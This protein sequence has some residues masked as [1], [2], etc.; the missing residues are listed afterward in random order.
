MNDPK[1]SSPPPLHKASPDYDYSNH[2][3]SLP[4]S[5][6]SS[7]RSA[8]S[9][10]PSS[11]SSR[12]QPQN[13]PT[14]KE[15]LR[16]LAEEQE[17][18]RDL[19]Q[20]LTFSTS[21]LVF[22]QDRADMAERKIKE[23]VIR[24]KDANDARI[25]AQADAARLREELKLYK[26]ALEEAQKEIFK[27]QN[28]LKD[29]EGRKREAEEEATQLRRKLRKMNEE[30]M[31]DMAREEGRKQGLEEGL[32]M[33]KDIGYLRG[34][35]QG[36]VNGRSTADKMMERYFSPPSESEARRSRGEPDLPPEGDVPYTATT[37]RFPVS[38][39]SAPS[40]SSSS[41]SE[42]EVSRY[43]RTGGTRTASARTTMYSPAQPH[44]EIPPDGFIPEVDAS[45]IIRLPPPHELV[46]PP[47]APA[48]Q[49]PSSRPVSPSPYMPPVPVPGDVPALMVPEPRSPGNPL[50]ELSG[51]RQHRRVRRRS[52]GESVSSSTRTSELDLLNA[53]E[54]VPNRG[55]RS[56]G[57]SVIPEVASFQEASTPSSRSM[58]QMGEDRVD[59]AGFVHV[60]MPAPLTAAEMA[61]LKARSGSQSLSVD[62][63]GYSRPGSTSSSGT[64]NITIQPP[65][66]PASNNSA[67]TTRP[68]LLS[69]ADADRPIPLP[70]QTAAVDTTDS[71]IVM[72]LPDGALPPGFVPAGLQGTETS[73]TGA[74]VPL[75]P[76]TMGSYHS[77]LPSQGYGGYDGSVRG[78]METPVVIPPPSGRSGHE[79][80]DDSSSDTDTLTTP[81][82]RYQV[83]SSGGYSAA[84]VALPGSIPHLGLHSASASGDI[85]LVQYALSHGQPVN[86]VLDGVLPLHAASAGGNVLVVNFLI[87][88]GADVNAPRLPR[89]YSDRSRDTTT[90]IVGTSGSTPLHFAAA[91]GHLP[92]VRTLLS[93]GAIPDRADK[94][95][96]TPELIARQNGW[97]ECAD[98]L[99]HASTSVKV[100]H[101]VSATT[102]SDAFSQQRGP[103]C[104]VEHLEASLRKRL[105]FKRSVDHTLSATG[106]TSDPE[107]K[108]PLA[109]SSIRSDQESL[110]QDSRLEDNSA[111]LATQT[112]PSPFGRPP[113]LPQ[114]LDESSI[115]P[116][117]PVR[118]V[119][120]RSAGTGADSRKLHSKLSLLSLFKKSNTDGSS[121]SV[122]SLSESPVP[123]SSPSRPVPIPTFRAHPSNTP[124]VSPRS[125]QIPLSSSPRDTSHRQYHRHK[126]ESSTSLINVRA[127]PLHPADLH[128]V[129]T[130]ERSRNPSVS[131]A[132]II[133]AP[134]DDSGSADGSPSI[135]GTPIKS[136]ILRMH[137][138]SH[139]GHGSI[140]QPGSLPRNI[141]FERSVSESTHLPG[142]ARSPGS[143][144]QLE[145]RMRS[146]GIAP[147]GQHEDEYDRIPDTIEESPIVPHAIP[148]VFVN[149]ILDHD[150]DPEEEYGIPLSNLELHPTQDHS[151]ANSQ[152]PFSINVP[153]TED[154]LAESR[155]RGDSV[156]S[157]STTAT[158]STY[159]QSSSSDAAWSITT[160][161]TPHL[162]GSP[163]I[164][165]ALGE[166]DVEETR[167]PHQPPRRLHFPFD[168]DISSI[169]SRA[170]AE[171]LVQRTQQS[172]LNM[173]QYIEQ[174]AERDSETG[175]TPLSAKLAAYGES[176]A[177]ERRLKEKA[178]VETP[179]Q[180]ADVGH[181]NGGVS[182]LSATKP[183]HVYPSPH[184]GRSAS[185]SGN[186]SQ[187]QQSE[188]L[189]QTT[190][191]DDSPGFASSPPRE[192]IQT[193]P[194]S[195]SPDANSDL[196]SSCHAGVPLSRVSTAPSYDPTSARRGRERD[197]SRSFQKLTRMGFSTFDNWHPSPVK[198]RASRSPP[199]SLRFG[200]RT[201]MQSFQGK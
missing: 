108:P 18:T 124:P 22:E 16:M 10:T 156:S 188:H 59:E 146:L 99:A 68:H 149:V 56:S 97:I 75:P 92:V 57:L 138:R 115:K 181:F 112:M 102:P 195:R 88:S 201:I 164:Q 153:P 2:E 73:Y 27:A 182:L 90:P 155:L 4:P 51:E 6:P 194:R 81:P 5:P 12:G 105:H 144:A 122:A 74:G 140:S 35:N 48:D 63:K 80:T 15:L 21:Q 17:T 150:D 189:R 52:S 154:A 197:P 85:G 171:E 161:S 76:S 132:S 29:I 96:I 19:Q 94:H 82:R 54:Y 89:R 62:Q 123:L 110:P 3:K 192:S 118:S 65:S 120:P 152:L 119:R 193:S 60:S 165:P 38:G 95:G 71:T 87:D 58:K 196:A 143:R 26:S 64:V 172:I 70:H 31:I 127:Y 69:P 133:S 41:S 160:P 24:F 117:F 78:E 109:A 177:I 20:Q 142:R 183:S 159:P 98:V 111:S 37:T 157:T 135:F 84:G 79:E 191:P 130:A 199:P 42:R 131:A 148:P 174:H 66:R 23:A 83:P 170:Q 185:S 134:D 163:R 9:R 129:L 166:S 34:R 67:A 113:S 28:I 106:G 39:G 100:G 162:P 47:P 104:S 50:Y 145:N 13:A 168:I 173:E 1:T 178:T 14:A 8:S 151:S 43:S 91:N 40:S 179:E 125:I 44:A 198:G 61:S 32:E 25:S 184:S 158:A 114:A 93:R 141:R 103:S 126:L 121:S 136:G 187:A 176:L 186:A 137:N 7:R 53:P 101:R 55:H 147:D 180:A 175:R 128:S 49:S 107:A 139:S 33:G 200:I 45:M 77:R 190:W 72:S 36:Y 30:K 11:R 86:S 116:A 167:E 46:R 169:S